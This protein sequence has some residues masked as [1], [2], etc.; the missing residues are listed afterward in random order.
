MPDN[1][2]VTAKLVS[3]GMGIKIP[4]TSLAA[5]IINGFYLEIVSGGQTTVYGVATTIGFD[6]GGL[7][8]YGIAT[9]AFGVNFDYSKGLS[10]HSLEGRL[11]DL[12]IDAGIVIAKLGSID[13]KITIYDKNNAP[14]MS[15]ERVDIEAQGIMIAD[16]KIRGQLVNLSKPNKK[17]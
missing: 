4:S 13:V 3:M 17:K 6:Q 5:N 10:P 1:Q 16:A 7:I 2:T 12:S 15:M 11:V 14:M 9:D 8:V